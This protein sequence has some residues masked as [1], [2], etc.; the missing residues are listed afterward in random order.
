[1]AL[2]V[3]A[4][5][6]VFYFPKKKSYLARLFPGGYCFAPVATELGCVGFEDAVMVCGAWQFLVVTDDSGV[7]PDGC[8]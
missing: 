2:G 7:R 5:G 6:F 1:M 4:I 3:V 8:S